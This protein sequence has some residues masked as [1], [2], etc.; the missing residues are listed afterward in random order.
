MYVAACMKYYAHKVINNLK[1]LIW[2]KLQDIRPT[3]ASHIHISIYFIQSSAA[4]IWTW[5][6]QTLTGVDTCA[7]LFLGWEPQREM[8]R[9]AT[10][11]KAE[12]KENPSKSVDRRRCSFHMD[13]ND[14]SSLFPSFVRYDNRMYDTRTYKHEF[15]PSH[16]VSLFLSLFRLFKVNVEDK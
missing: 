7:S 16:S 4:R 2:R 14:F 9:G 15:T 1:C 6:S 10:I 5:V 13:L 11:I 12:K 8:E 3:Y